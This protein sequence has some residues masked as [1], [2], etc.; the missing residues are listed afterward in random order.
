MNTETM[1]ELLR[2]Q[3]FQPFE[4]RMSNGDAYQ[5]RHPEMA[6]LLRSNVIVGDRDTDRFVFCS[7][8]H[9]ADVVS[10]PSPAGGGPT[11]RENGAGR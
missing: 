8:L 5:I 3:P 4:I 7:L 11:P 9:V 1:L 6:L 10:L 2:R